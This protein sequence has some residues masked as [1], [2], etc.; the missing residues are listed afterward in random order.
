MPMP[1]RVIEPLHNFSCCGTA[2][3]AHLSVVLPSVGYVQPAAPQG[4]TLPLSFYV[5]AGVAPATPM[6]SLPSGSQRASITI[7]R[8]VVRR[9]GA[10]VLVSEDAAGACAEGLGV[11]MLLLSTGGKVEAEAPL[12]AL[13]QWDGAMA[14]QKVECL[15]VNMDIPSFSCQVLEV[16]YWIRVHLSWPWTTGP[17]L[18]VPLW[19]GMR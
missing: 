4:V 11:S 15:C 14:L 13:C 9:A 5:G 1:Q 16:T 19:V 6:L 10:K 18:E 17:T 3:V 2:G 12:A 8:R 7:V